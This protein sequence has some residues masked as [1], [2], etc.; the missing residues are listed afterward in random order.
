MTRN[1]LLALLLASMASATVM[2]EKYDYRFNNTPLAEAILRIATD[3]PDFPV[4]FIYNELNNYKTSARVCTDDAAQVLSTLV[5]LNPV[6]VTPHKNRYYVEALQHGRHLYRGRLTDSEGQGLPSGAVYALQPKD[7]TV[8]TYAVTDQDGFF[9]LP[10]DHASILVKATYMGLKPKVITPQRYNLGTIVLSDNPTMLK[11]VTVE[12]SAVAYASDK[13]T[14]L[15]TQRQKN[16]SQSAVDLLRQMAIPQLR[17]TAGDVTDN[18]GTSVPIFINFR[19]ATGQEIKGLNVADVRKVEF[20]ESPTDP[21][22]R[23]APRAINIIVQQYTYGG[24]TKLTVAEAALTGLES[25]AQVYSK[26][27]AGSMTYDV[28]ADAN[29]TSTHKGGYNSTEVYHLEQGTVK[30]TETIDKARY[31]TNKYPLTFQAAY[32][33]KN[34]QVTN[35]VSFT[36]GATPTET[37][38][39]SLALGDVSTSYTRTTPSRY[40]TLGYSGEVYGVLPKNWTLDIAPE[41]NYTHRNNYSDYAS[42]EGE[43]IAVHAREDATNLRLDL[44]LTKRFDNRHSL[45]LTASGGGMINRLHYAGT[46]SYDNRYSVLYGYGLAAYTF[47]SQKVYL[48]ADAGYIVEHSNVDGHT[49]NDPYPGIHLRGTYTFSKK[50]QVGAY[51]QFASQTPGIDQKGDNVIQ[52]NELLYITANPDLNNVRH[53]TGQTWYNWSPNNVLSLSAYGLYYGEIKRITTVYQPYRNGTALLRQYV[54][55]GNYNRALFGGSC[56]ARLLDGKLQLYVYLNNTV[57][58]TSGIYTRTYN[59]LNIQTGAEYYMGNFWLQGS[60]I[61]PKRTPDIPTNTAVSGRSYYQLQGGW[62]NSSWKVR[63]G[64]ANFFSRTDRVDTQTM[65]SPLLDKTVTRFGT[66]RCPQINMSVTYIIGY[67]KKVSQSREVSAHDNAGSAMLK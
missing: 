36:H 17:V 37:V 49:R 51:F 18:F 33:G 16:S 60:W 42:Q 15:P 24:Y 12:S 1:R 25:Q 65:Q 59:D 54:N 67:G 39:G 57:H 21:R 13:N 32:N 5:G 44:N 45:T 64:V 9:V 50:S 56:T 19:K 61:S 3:H 23:G 35:M 46:D 11:A 27:S 8:I 20:L 66:S 48:Y 26:F 22:F 34:L 7:S 30:R 28:S 47:N 4:N 62:G 52:S 10:C 53:I 29:N 14:Y 55:N 43:K 41:L 58:H 2:A 6:T 38:S 40:N 63:A 31:T